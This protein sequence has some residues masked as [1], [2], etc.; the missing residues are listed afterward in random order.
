MT[1]KE[2]FYRL[3]SELTA[4]YGDAAEARSVARV[5][6]EDGLNIQYP[7]LKGELGPADQQ[8]L[9]LCQERLL[10][11]EPIQYITGNAWFYGD[12]FL[13]TPAVLI[14]RPET[15]ELVEWVLQWLNREVKKE[16]SPRVL[17]VGTGSGCIA[18]EIKKRYPNSVLTALDIQRD[19]LSLARRNAALLGV[20]MEFLELDILDT[21]SWDK[22]PRFDVLV[23]NPPYV[24]E[25]ERPQMPPQVRDFEPEIALFVPDED[26]L[27]FYTALGALALRKLHSG[28]ALFAECHYL[29]CRDVAALWEG[30]GLT[31]LE[32]R[33]DL[34]G[35]ERMVKAICPQAQNA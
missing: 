20:E 27:R 17:D 32:I 13:V 25:A 1:A 10:K 6:F 29:K 7:L 31:E 12:R 33:R 24:L 11:G 22:L 8:Y 18:I 28:G 5:L 9:A 2:G 30:M 15:E 21:A 14:P 16:A 23:S 3:L 19:A 34:Y 35:H 26:P 4:C